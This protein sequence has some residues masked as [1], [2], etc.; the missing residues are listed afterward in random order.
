MTQT[1]T[2][3]RKEINEAIQKLVDRHS[4]VCHDNDVLRA[5][6]RDKT[7]RIEQLEIDIARL[8]ASIVEDKNPFETMTIDS[9]V[10]D[11]DQLLIQVKDLA[12]KLR[13]T[14]NERDRFQANLVDARATLKTQGYRID[15]LRSEKENLTQALNEQTVR[16]NNFTFHVAE[17]REDMDRCKTYASQLETVNKEFRE[18]IKNPMISHSSFQQGFQH[19]IQVLQAEAEKEIDKRSNRPLRGTLINQGF[20]AAIRILRSKHKQQT[21]LTSKDLE[22]TLEE[23]VT[24]LGGVFATKSPSKEEKPEG[25]WSQLFIGRLCGADLF[26]GYA[27]AEYRKATQETELFKKDLQR[28]I[29]GYPITGNAPT[30]PT[31]HI[32]VERTSDTSEGIMNVIAQ[33]ERLGWTVEVRWIAE[34]KSSEPTKTDTTLTDKYAPQIT[35]IVVPGEHLSAA[36]FLETGDS[37]S[38]AEKAGCR[39]FDPR[40]TVKVSQETP[41][42]R[43]ALKNLVDAVFD[44]ENKKTPVTGKPTCACHAAEKHPKEHA[45]GCP[46]HVFYSISPLED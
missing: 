6:N 34:K 23:L 15:H 41:D 32:F 18:E 29:E 37:V 12:E 46:V 11:R 2:D 14:T 17:L 1:T 4:L 8:G 22:K 38:E 3:I 13:I 40:Q 19:A 5:D 42:V 33:L 36:Y 7:Q 35:A 30:H 20:M 9:L 10:H 25:G 21:G 39:P 24:E 45:W 44:A 16:V 28:L 27:A 43:E 31:I 26:V